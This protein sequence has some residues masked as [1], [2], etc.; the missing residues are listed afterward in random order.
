MSSPI[1]SR[2][3]IDQEFSRI[4]TTAWRNTV[5]PETIAYVRCL[6]KIRAKTEQ[7]IGYTVLCDNL[8]DRYTDRLRSMK[9]E[10]HEHTNEKKSYWVT[11]ED[12]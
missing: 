9:Y 1:F 3:N 8:S 12:Y 10:L 5:Y 4:T 6:S 2:K 11:W 7:N